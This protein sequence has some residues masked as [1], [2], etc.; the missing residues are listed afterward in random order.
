MDTTWVMYECCLYLISEEISIRCYAHTS[1]SIFDTHLFIFVT[2]AIRI[3]IRNRSNLYSYLYSRLSVFESESSRKYENKYNIDDIVYIRSIYISTGACRRRGGG[4][5]DRRWC[6]IAGD[7]RTPIS[8]GKDQ[9]GSSDQ[10]RLAVARP[11][12]G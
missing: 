11:A 2:E 5:R 12:I 4:G 9:V 6:R 10:R 7:N 8:N 3:R 1:R